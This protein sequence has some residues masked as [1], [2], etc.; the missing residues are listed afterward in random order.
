MTETQIKEDL[1]KPAAEPR[2]LEA[3]ELPIITAARGW[4]IG[5][6]V[7]AFVLGAVVGHFVK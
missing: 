6:A 1:T 3:K 7:G 5:T 2:V 4:L